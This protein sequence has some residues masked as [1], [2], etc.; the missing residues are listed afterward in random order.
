MEWDCKDGCCGHTLVG[1]YCDCD[2]KAGPWDICHPQKSYSCDL[3][4]RNYWI[5]HRDD[6]SPVGE[7]C[8][9]PDCKGKLGPGAQRSYATYYSLR[10]Q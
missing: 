10:M 3:C 7:N 9:G 5:H 6:V 4:G 1:D 2:N 8:T